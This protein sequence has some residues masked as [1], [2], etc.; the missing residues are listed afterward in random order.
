MKIYLIT[1]E[2][3]HWI[4]FYPQIELVTTHMEAD[5]ILYE[6]Y[7][8]PISE[9]NCVKRM[10]PKNKLVFIISS[11]RTDHQDDECIWFTTAVQ[12]KLRARQTQLH[13]INPSVFRYISYR[14]SDRHQ[15]TSYHDD[16]MKTGDIYF[17]GTIW[18][19]RQEMFDYFNSKSNHKETTSHNEATTSE[20]TDSPI[21]DDIAKIV[22]QLI[23]CKIEPFNHYWATIGANNTNN[24]NDFITESAFDMYDDMS[25]YKLSLCPKGWGLSSMRIIESLVCR[26]IP[27]LIDDFTAPFGIDWKT[28]GLVFDTTKQSWDEIYEEILDLLAD[29]PRMKKLKEE[30][31][32]IFTEILSADLKHGPCTSFKT[33]IWG[34]SHMVVK[35]LEKY[36]SLSRRTPAIT[37]DSPAL[38]A[39]INNNNKEIMTETSRIFQDVYTQATWGASVIPNIAGGSGGGSSVE[40]AKTYMEFLENFMKEYDIKSVVDLGSGDWQFSRHVNWGDRSYTGI[41]CVAPVV[42]AISKQFTK[43]NIKFM[44]LDF[45]HYPNDIPNADLYVIKDVLQHWPNELI[46]DFLRKI[47]QAK[48]MKYLI[49]T[50]CYNQPQFRYCPIGKFEPLNPTLLPL[51]EFNPKVVLQ[52]GSKQVCLIY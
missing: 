10:Y 7:S 21:F 14:D 15:N 34:S 2:S 44:C 5:F 50:N 23:N 37:P 33:V 52:Y 38:S 13:C 9:I 47:I 6:K 4:P 29:E 30:G 18:P 27:V 19:F 45:G 16:V 1:P 49:I 11:L 17:K 43:D 31:Q 22:P 25:K 28:I 39:N 12:P 26:C 20:E 32:R 40:S 51:S 24:A 46:T 36:L 41:D 42:S 48:K 35:Q 8:N 3:L